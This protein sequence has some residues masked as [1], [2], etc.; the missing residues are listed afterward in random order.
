MA[1]ICTVYSPRNQ[2][3]LAILAVSKTVQDAEIDLGL[4]RAVALELGGE[5]ADLV[6]ELRDGLGSLCHRNLN[7]TRD[8]L[9]DVQLERLQLVRVGRLA[10]HRERFRRDTLH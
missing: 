6:R 1:I 2:D 8:L 9:L 7:I 3:V 4:V 5:H 10:N